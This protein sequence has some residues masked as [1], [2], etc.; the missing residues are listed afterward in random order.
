MEEGSEG[1]RLELSLSEG[2]DIRED[3]FYRFA[4]EHLPLLEMSMEHAS[5]EEVFI[6][7]TK[8]EADN[9]ENQDNTENEQEAAES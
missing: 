7:L 6:D 5:L 4:D 9:T 2:K 8:D 1:I 3:L